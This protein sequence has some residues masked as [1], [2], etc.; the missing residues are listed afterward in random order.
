M[1]ENTDQ[2]GDIR[3]ACCWP[4]AGKRGVGFSRANLFG[5]NFDDYFLEAQQPVLVAM[6]E[7]VKAIENLESILAGEGLDSILIGPYDLS[8]S[9]GITGD[10]SDKVFIDALTDIKEK[11]SAANIPCGVHVIQPSPAELEAHIKDGYRFLAYSIDTVFLR[12]IMSRP[13]V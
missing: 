5:E 12:S 13:D 11:A 3:E 7:S 1:V 10:F 8:A 2:L 6:I 4:P 9:L